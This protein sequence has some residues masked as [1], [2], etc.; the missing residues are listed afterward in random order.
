[1]WGLLVLG[2]AV[3]GTLQ[4]VAGA[5]LRQPV[6]DSVLT[7]ETQPPLSFPYEIPGTPLV[8]VNPVSYEGPFSSAEGAEPVSDGLALLL[9]NTADRE[10][11]HTLVV[12]EKADRQYYFAATHI[13]PEASILVVEARHAPWQDGPFD[14]CTGSIQYAPG[15]SIPETVLKIEDAD[16]GAVALTNLGPEPLAA[17]RLYYKNYLP[18][19]DMYLGGGTFT[20]VVDGIAPGETVTVPLNYYASGYSRILKA[21]PAT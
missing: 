10:L 9:K 7:L 17:L 5:A 3:Y 1:M 16:L 15:E 14:S 2:L 12:L 18:E 6:T 4:T 13:P 11:L 19:Q 21:E 8:A 20:K